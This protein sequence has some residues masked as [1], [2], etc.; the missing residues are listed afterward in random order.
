MPIKA[1]KKRKS[2]TMGRVLT[3]SKYGMVIKRKQGEGG[4]R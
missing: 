4:L 1:K 2:R 3:G